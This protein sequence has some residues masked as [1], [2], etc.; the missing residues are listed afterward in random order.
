MGHQMALADGAQRLAPGNGRIGHH[1]QSKD[2]SDQIPADADRTAGH[3][4][5]L[6]TALVQGADFFAEFGD[7]RAV[8]APLAGGDA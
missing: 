7:H 2:I 8:D 6:D 5:G 1:R 3:Q 4:N